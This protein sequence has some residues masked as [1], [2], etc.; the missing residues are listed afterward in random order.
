M[1]KMSSGWGAISLQKRPER[2]Q[3]KRNSEEDATLAYLVSKNHPRRRR[4]LGFTGPGPSA[5]GS[6]GLRADQSPQLLR[7]N[8]ISNSGETNSKK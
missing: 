6:Q 8:C 7:K 3:R 1:G 2:A 5:K 4:E